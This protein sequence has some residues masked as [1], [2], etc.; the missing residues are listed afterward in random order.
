MGLGKKIK[1]KRKLKAKTAADRMATISGQ[2]ISHLTT[3]Q[4]IRM[5][6]KLDRDLMQDAKRDLKGKSQT[7]K[8]IDATKKLATKLETKAAKEEIR[9]SYSQTSHDKIDR[10]AENLHHVQDEMG[11]AKIRKASQ[12]GAVS[13][14]EGYEST[15]DKKSKKRKHKELM[16]EQK[17]KH[18]FLRKKV[19]INIDSH[20]RADVDIHRDNVGNLGRRFHD[21][22]RKSIPDQP[23]I[24]QPTPPNPPTPQ[25]RFEDPIDV[26]G[27]RIE[28]RR[29][30][31]R[32]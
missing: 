15:A 27:E 23:R 24:P 19:D 1:D 18:R 3:G 8:D 16:Q 28:N 13:R 9:Q 26:Y 25:P 32:R 30:N 12:G 17:G 6:R 2:D 20:D 21:K 7:A 5:G 29:P 4:Q 14:M 22:K 11:Q 10:L 31:G